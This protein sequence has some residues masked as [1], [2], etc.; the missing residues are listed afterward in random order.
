[1]KK[2]EPGTLF[3]STKKGIEYLFEAQAVGKAKK[4]GRLTPYQFPNKAHRAGTGKAPVAAPPP[5][6]K[7][8]KLSTK[9][10]S[11]DPAIHVMVRKDNRT[12]VQQLRQVA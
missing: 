3:K 6:K 4:V 8:N 2:L 1:M 9:H 12:W 11:F 5:P 10:S 7:V